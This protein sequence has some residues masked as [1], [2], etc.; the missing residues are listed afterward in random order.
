MNNLNNKYSLNEIKQIISNKKIISIDFG[1]KRIGL[2]TCDSM[3]ISLAP[4]ATLSF[5]DDIIHNLAKIITNEKI[6]VILIG[7][8][9]WNQNLNSDFFDNLNE[10]TS[11]L[12]EEIQ[13]PILFYD[14]AF[15]SKR[16][17][18]YMVQLGKKR[19]DRQK[20]ENLDK[21]AAAVILKSFLEET[22][23]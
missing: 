18:E 20:K 21:I 12:E 6:G 8:P 13:L 1:L 2:A 22:E 16:G 11:R 4:L 15:S 10:F 7:I 5:D 23:G 9:V 19:K 3:H 14:E 17:M